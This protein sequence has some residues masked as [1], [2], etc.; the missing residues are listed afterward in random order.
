MCLD[1][2][3]NPVTLS[4]GHTFD[5]A[6]L[7]RL[8]TPTQ[9]FATPCPI[10]RAPMPPMLPP[11]NRQMADLVEAAHPARVAARLQ[12]AGPDVDSDLSDVES[13]TPPPPLCTRDAKG[14]HIAVFGQLPSSFLCVCVCMRDVKEVHAAVCR[15]LP[16]AFLW[17]GGWVCV[18]VYER[19]QRSAHRRV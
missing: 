3:H 6:C 15:Q 10:C 16:S 9:G 19:R 13:L 12:L 8:P 14:V 7:K 17:V 1:V 11:V 4:C 5:L 2:L 18:C